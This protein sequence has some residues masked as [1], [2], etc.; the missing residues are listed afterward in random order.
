VRLSPRVLVFVF[1]VTTILA[2][3]YAWRQR[4]AYLTLRASFDRKLEDERA[5]WRTRSTEAD[6]RAHEPEDDLAAR[7]VP[8]EPSP[9][10]SAESRV[11]PSA[12]PPVRGT[13]PRR[14]AS[15]S[16]VMA[17]HPELQQLVLQQQ[18]SALDER[19]SALFKALKLSPAALEKF[20][21]LLVDRQNIN[22]DVQAAAR[23]KGLTWRDNADD[24][25]K[26]TNDAQAEV[27]QSIRA[28]LGEAVFNQY[29][30]F[31]QT[32]VQRGVVDQLDRRLSYLGSEL[33]DQQS[34][35]L[36][37]ILA[38]NPPVREAPPGAAGSGGPREAANNRLI[39]DAAIAQAAQVLSPPQL[40]ALRQLQTEQRTQQ[41]IRQLYRQYMQPSA[42]ADN[43]GG[44]AQKK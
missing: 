44:S 41:Q 35:K 2:V 27:D 11:A 5:A 40:A 12:P 4:E 14:G 19:Y 9:T 26:L 3:G 42:P 21:A 37:A 29:K 38:A 25:R 39:S 34:E 30:Q 16:E 36:V 10:V 6:H 1:L 18:K 15:F 13:A 31:E 20:K 23:E 24:I 7:G 33:Q 43:S 22:T 8:V 17:Q 28:S 32:G